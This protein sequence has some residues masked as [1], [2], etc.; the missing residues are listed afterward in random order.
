MGEIKRH[1]Q[2]TFV[3]KAWLINQTSR[4]WCESQDAVSQILWPLTLGSTPLKQRNKTSI[5]V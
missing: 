2:D 4:R 3:F 1:N 5:W